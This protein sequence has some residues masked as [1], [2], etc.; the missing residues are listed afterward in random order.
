MEQQTCLECGEGVDDVGGQGIQESLTCL[1]FCDKNVCECRHLVRSEL[2]RTSLNVIPDFVPC[3]F[4]GA[5]LDNSVEVGINGP[6]LM[7]ELP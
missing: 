4:R 7:M 6:H 5:W 1:S 2:I 3:Y